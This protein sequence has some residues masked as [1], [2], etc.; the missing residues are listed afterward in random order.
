[1]TFCHM[2]DILGSAYKK[3][4]SSEFAGV[5]H[6]IRANFVSSVCD[7]GTAFSAVGIVFKLYQQT[8]VII[9]LINSRVVCKAKNVV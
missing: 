2:A 3:Y 8:N 7:G 4:R 6:P 5:S 9:S 1:M